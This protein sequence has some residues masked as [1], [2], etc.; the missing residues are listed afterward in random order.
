MKEILSDIVAS[1]CK[2]V[3]G[4]DKGGDSRAKTT[5]TFEFDTSLVIMDLLGDYEEGE[6]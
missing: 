3:G 5:N 1:P 2:L 4:G 6:L